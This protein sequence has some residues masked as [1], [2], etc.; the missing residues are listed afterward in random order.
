MVSRLRGGRDVLALRL[1]FDELG[2]GSTLIPFRAVDFI[3]FGVHAMSHSEL[4]ALLELLAMLLWDWRTGTLFLLLIIAAV[5][6]HRSHRI[7][8]WLVLSGMLFGVIYNFAYPPFLRAGALWPLEGW[9]LGFI[10]FLPL[11]L[12]RAMGAG[13]VK[14]MAMVGAF[15]GPVDIVWVLLSTM[16]AGG[17]LSIALVLS[18]GTAARLLRNLGDIFRLGYLNTVGGFKPELHIGAAASA[19]K[20]PYGVAIASG[21]IVYLTLHQLALL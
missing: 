13:D 20:L 11:Y 18:R 15:V 2:F 17:V 21:T 8:N 19:G 5:I 14:L 7:P 6:D 9:A 4:N 16:I 3:T 1:D 12:L 10:V